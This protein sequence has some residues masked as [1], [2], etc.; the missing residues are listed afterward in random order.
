[1]YKILFLLLFHQIV[2][3][4]NC[5]IRIDP[6]SEMCGVEN[7]KLFILD[8][9][10]RKVDIKDGGNSN[11]MPNRNIWNGFYCPVAKNTKGDKLN[12]ELIRKKCCC[13]RN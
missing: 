13:L 11:D 7:N 10:D 1:M 4:I 12:A 9:V 3:A 5:P 6:P 8:G 2:F